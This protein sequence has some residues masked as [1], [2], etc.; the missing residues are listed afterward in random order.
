M[1]RGTTVLI[2]LMM[3]AMSL[4]GCAGG[5]LEEQISDLEAAAESDQATIAGLEAI[6]DADAATISAQ[7]G[8]I[9]ALQGQVS[10]LE[11]QIAANGNVTQLEEYNSQLISD[12]TQLVAQ[13]NTLKDDLDNSPTQ[14]DLDAAY[15]QGLLAG[16]DTSTLDVILARGSM[17]CG[18]KESQYGMGYLDAAT[19][20][21]SGLDISYC[22]AVAAAIGLDP[23]TDVEYIPASGSDRFE[24]LASGVIDVL[25][26]TTTWTTS[27]DADLNADFAGMNFFDGQG[28][29]I[30]EDRFAAAASGNSA[31]A[32][33]GANICVGIGTTTEGNMQDWFSSRDIDFTSV[34]VADAAEATAKFIDGSCDAF[35]GDMSAMVAK[36][37]Q[38]ERDGSM[39]GVDIWIASELMSKEPLGAATRDHDSE[40]NEVV[41]WVW[42]GMV[43]AEEMGVTSGNYATKANEACSSGAG[44]DPGMCRLL[45]ENLGLGTATN[46]LAGTWMQ[47]VLDAVGN[48]GEAYDEAFCDGDYDGV[49][50]SAAMN[51]CLISRTGTLNALVSEGGIQY[52]P[53]MR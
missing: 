10:S 39:G 33:D 11:D 3:I 37:W 22:R 21:R 36:K 2:A 5:D 46:P 32:L 52:A 26:R 48:Y 44:Y 49:S 1:N 45:T 34:P 18:V 47:E 4:A 15:T 24:K 41:A 20:V 19:G 16:S 23:D 17:K 42:Y 28:I 13:V 50:G 40:W 27:R 12:N 6:A 38:L 30:R 25:I 35:T 8:Q 31:T 14:D 53:P 29:L 43:T 51:D 7:S 9:S